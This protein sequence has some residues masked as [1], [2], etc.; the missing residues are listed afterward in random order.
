MI[1]VIK[2]GGTSLGTAARV[3]TAARRVRRLREL[4]RRPVVVV[5]ATGHTTDRILDRLTDVTDGHLG[6]AARECDRALA[7]GEELSAA[8]VAAALNA[9]D[10]PAVSLRG[11]EAGIRASGGF[12]AGVPE[13]LDPAP[14][15]HLLERGLVPVVAG[16]QGRRPDGETV[17]L[18]RGGS[19]ISAV[20]L[21]A[22]LGA[23]CHIVTDVDGVYTADPRHD[24]AARRYDTLSHAELV[25]ITGAGAEVVH[26]DAAERAARAGIE[27]RV[28][29]F[30][31]PLGGGRGTLVG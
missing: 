4:G 6:G 28:Y 10:V 14:L 15:T 23:E 3:R 25:G 21:A 1:T 16:F 13:S 5:S 7:S 27:L 24:P 8:L 19:D 22:A 17:T 29:S 26:P 2:F 9:L 18:G 11:G 30:R 31:A 12:G 20:F